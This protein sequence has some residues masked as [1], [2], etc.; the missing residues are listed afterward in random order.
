MRAEHLNG[1]SLLSLRDW[2][3]VD[4]RYLLRLSAALRQRRRQGLRS[5]SL[6]GKSIVMLFEKTSTRTRTA[7][8]L[9]MVD[10]GGHATMLGGS[11]LGAKESVEDTARVLGRLYDGIQFRG[12]RQEDVELLAGTAG[13]PVWNGLTD[14]FHPTQALADVLTMQQ[15]AGAEPGMISVCFVGDGRNNVARSLLV[16]GAKLGMDVRVA[17]PA[18]LHPDPAFL[19]SL[20]RFA[21]ESGA[22]LSVLEDPIEAV[23]DCGFVYTDVWVSMGEEAHAS[24]RLSVL[25][26]YRVT[27]ELMAASGREDTGFLHCLPALHDFNTEISRKFREQTGLDPR[28]VTDEVFRSPASLVFEQAENRLHTIKALVAT[29]MGVDLTAT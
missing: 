23:R 9:A 20:E 25:Q 28:E 15:A 24:E 19:A 22:S 5:Q 27:R 21:A 14:D 12:S 7:F 4:I 17:S 16:I 1:K 13:V 26:N 2:E 6:A 10:E 3:A 8:E 18:E 29:T 11:Q